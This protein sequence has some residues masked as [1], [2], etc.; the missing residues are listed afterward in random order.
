MK[1]YFVTSNQGK[2]HSLEQN[3][4]RFSIPIDI[5]PVKLPLIE[6]QASTV[7]E[8]SRSKAKQAFEILHEPV[9]VEDGGFCIEALSDFP[10]VYT[11]YVLDTIGVD[12][13]LRLMENVDNRNC[14]FVSTMTFADKQGNLHSFD[15]QGGGGLL[16]RKKAKQTAEKIWSD[17]WL[18]FEVPQFKKALSTLTKEELLAVWN[19]PNSE[20]SLSGFTKWF[21]KHHSEVI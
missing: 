13:I 2:V 15:R 3:L 5:K 11:R 9:I 20:S 1:L 21:A 12:G 14:R 4:R 18:I 10:G 8:V 17:V 6:P 16:L 7:R 19:S